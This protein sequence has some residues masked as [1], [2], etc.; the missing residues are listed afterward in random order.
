MLKNIYVYEMLTAILR[1]VYK[2]VEPVRLLSMFILNNISLILTL[3]S[4][5]SAVFS[6]FWDL[7]LYQCTG[8]IPF[9]QYIL[10]NE[11]SQS[12]ILFT[13]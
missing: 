10:H 6:S 7:G 4:L 5:I 1:L 13:S 9:L 11:K 8:K 3:P 12:C 2:P